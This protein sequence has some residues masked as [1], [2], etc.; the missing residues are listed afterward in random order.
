MTPDPASLDQFAQAIAALFNVAARQVTKRRRFPFLAPPDKV[1]RVKL[2][3]GGSVKISPERIKIP[4][5]ADHQ[6]FAAAI[7]LA[8]AAWGEAVAYGS[9]RFQRKAVAYGIFLGINVQAKAR[10]SSR[11]RKLIE[12]EVAKLEGMS[13]PR[14]NPQAANVIH[15]FWPQF[16]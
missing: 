7:R 9:K 13:S 6:S 15:T 1:T 16:T 5:R 4:A 12:K 8:G 11:D 3:E 14:P 2:P 10:L